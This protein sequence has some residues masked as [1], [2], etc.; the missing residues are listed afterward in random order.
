M[1]TQQGG[2]V[3]EGF[4]MLVGA[5]CVCFDAVVVF[6]SPSDA[7]IFSE[8]LSFQHIFLK[9][10]YLHMYRE[11]H[12]SFLILRANTTKKE[13]APYHNNDRKKI[14]HKATTMVLASTLEHSPG[15]GLIL[16]TSIHAVKESGHFFQGA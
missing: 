2:T 8:Q 9:Y 3:N 5:R 12:I 6:A 4:G 13:S 7:A 10:I 11:N 15:T 1:Q 14:K 16:P